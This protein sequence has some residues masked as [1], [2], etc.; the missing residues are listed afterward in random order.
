MPTRTQLIVLIGLIVLITACS[1]AQPTALFLPTSP[2]R[3]TSSPTPMPT[4]VPTLTS[5]SQMPATPIPDQAA[6]EATYTAAPPDTA[7]PTQEQATVEPTPTVITQPPD[8]AFPPVI[9]LEPWLMDFEAP[10]FITYAT[11]T[12]QWESRLFVVE[13]PGR[14]QLV[15]GGQVRPI[16]FL[17]ITNRVGASSSKDC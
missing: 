3:P 15:E 5:E 17:D 2:P 4:A 16:P 14:I 8:D 7:S 1:E 9:G 10:V 13:K 6:V 12:S 11:D